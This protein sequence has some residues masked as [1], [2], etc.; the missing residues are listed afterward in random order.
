MRSLHRLAAFF[1]ALSLSCVALAAEIDPATYGYPISNPFEATITSTP[2]AQQPALPA[3]DDIDQSDYT[4]DLMPERGDK[5]PDTFWA[6]KQLR[7]RLARQAGPA[8]LMFIIAGT[9]ASYNESKMEF[10]KKLFYGAGYHVVQISSPTSFNFIVAASTNATPGISADDAKDLYRVMGAI[11]DQHHDLQVTRYDITGYSLGALNAAFVSKLDEGRKRFNFSRVLLLNPPVNL[12]TSVSNLDSLVHVRLPGVTSQYTFLDE[13]LDKMTRYF[14]AEGRINVDAA[15]VFNFQNS[16][17]RL[18]NEQM[19]MIIGASFRSSSADIIFTSDL[20]NQR[21]LIT[22][23][24][25]EIGYGTSMVPFFRKALACDFICYLNQQMLPYWQSR[26]PGGDLEQLV[27]ETGLVALEDY[28]K[29]SPKIAVFHNADDIILGPGDL[30]F[31]R[32]TF[33]NRLTVYPLGGHCGNINYRVNT[34]AMLEFF[35]G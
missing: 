34:D 4:L 11:S 8:P 16:K 22:P 13:L 28:L 32:S 17:E 35:R 21:N 12:Y 9:G 31:L 25:S 3:D 26:N 14:S 27:H 30:G 18:S 7:Y 33:G 19:A 23:V 10:L 29:S 2:P 5:M 15:T 20:I 24:G 1:G 6:V